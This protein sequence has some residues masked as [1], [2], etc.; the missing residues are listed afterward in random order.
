MPRSAIERARTTRR[1]PD[2]RVGAPFNT[3]G[4]YGTNRQL[5]AHQRLLRLL[6][7]DDERQRRACDRE[8]PYRAHRPCDQC[9]LHRLLSGERQ[10]L[11]R[12]TP[13]AVGSSNIYNPS[14]LIPVG[15]QARAAAEEGQ[16]DHPQE[17]GRRRH[18]V[19]PGR[20][21]PRHRWA[22]VTEGGSRM[23]SAPP[24]GCRRA[25]TAPKL[26][27]AAGRRD[28]QAVAERLAVR[29]LCRRAVAGHP[30]PV[31]LANRGPNSAPFDVEAE[32]SRRQGRLGAP[33][34]T[35]RRRVQITRPLTTA[36]PAKLPRSMTA[37]SESRHRAERLWPADAG[38]ARYD[39]HTILSPR[40]P[41]RATVA[42]IGTGRPPACPYHVSASLDWDTPWVSGLS[43]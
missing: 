43:R 9:R 31:A 42:E 40:S 4:V 29:E 3:S 2:S 20:D 23:P 5:P 14:P 27:L 8:V 12:Q 10:R 36:T 33:S 34:R 19:V 32:G 13:A 35:T 22:H 6:Q 24:L 30:L 41:S 18:D 26:D 11:C 7:Q 25:A 28:R 21:D 39:E 15:S 17:H 16:R 38:P 1:S 37:S